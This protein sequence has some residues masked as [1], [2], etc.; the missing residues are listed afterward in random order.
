MRPIYQTIVTG[1]GVLTGN[2]PVVLDMYQNPTA[3]S[4]TAK[5]YGNN[6][7]TIQISYDDPFGTYSS[8]YSGNATWTNSGV[9]NPGATTI[10]R[11]TDAPIRAL[12]YAPGGVTN[13]GGLILT[14]IQAGQMA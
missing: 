14:V 10:F 13:S 6:S 2:D 12:R 7:G 8:S 11:Y 4:V 1:S 3:I 5:S 9:V